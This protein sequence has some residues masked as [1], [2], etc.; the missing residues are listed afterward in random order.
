MPNRKIPKVALVMVDSSNESLIAALTDFF[1]SIN[2]V[3]YTLEPSI[4]ADK[5]SVQTKLVVLC[6]SINNENDVNSHYDVILTFG[7]IGCRRNDVVPEA[8]SDVIQKALPALAH[9]FHER[10]EILS[11]RPVFGL[12]DSSVIANL[13]GVEDLASVVKEEEEAVKLIVDLTKRL[14]RRCWQV[15]A[16]LRER[17]PSEG[18]PTVHSSHPTRKTRKK[19]LKR[20]TDDTEAEAGLS[21]THQASCPKQPKKRRLRELPHYDESSRVPFK[22]EPV[23]DEDDN[24]V[25]FDESGEEGEGTPNVGNVADVESGHDQNRFDGDHGYVGISCGDIR[26]PRSAL[27]SNG[28]VNRVRTGKALF[29]FLKSH[30]L[31]KGIVLHRSKRELKKNLASVKAKG[32]GGKGGNPSLSVTAERWTRNG[33]LMN[34]NWLD[35]EFE[36]TRHGRE[37]RQKYFDSG[38]VGAKNAAVCT[39][40]LNCPGTATCQRVCG[41]VG[42]CQPGC[43]GKTYKLDRHNCQLM[44]KMQIFLSDVDTWV[45]SCYGRHNEDNTLP[46]VVASSDKTKGGN[47]VIGDE[48]KRM[49]NSFIFQERI[50]NRDELLLRMKNHYYSCNM[51]EMSTQQ[52]QKL[53]AFIDRYLAKHT[54]RSAR[55]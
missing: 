29:D 25:V 36:L 28:E 12:R 11:L 1:Q 23:T 14:V 26:D 22:S 35:D 13:P 4:N 9:Y 2:D 45:V 55:T 49:L 46:D 3:E 15:G 52:A 7:G 41:G 48:E 54:R 42:T 37:C 43:R 50:F 38:G 44:V 8:T 39:W 18:H 34:K 53:L 20:T 21:I 40:Y 19:K 16:A 32:G 24:T 51:V 30:S 17:T 47:R 10:C 31:T 27:N 5:S 6:N 33:K